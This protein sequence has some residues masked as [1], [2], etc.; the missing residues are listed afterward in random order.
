MKTFNLLSMIGLVLMFFSVNKELYAGAYIFAGDANGVD[1]VAHSKNY[2]GTGG[3]ITNKVCIVVGSNSAASLE[4]PVQN[5][6]D[7]FNQLVA[8]EGNLLTGANNDIAFNQVDIESALLHEIGHC[9]GMAHPNAA[10]ESGLPSAD[11][12]YTKATEGTNAVFD[13]NSGV[14]GVRG[15]SDD[16]RGDDENLHWFL[17]DS[18]NPF[19]TPDGAVDQSNYSRDLADLPLG[20]SFATNA[21]RTVSGLYGLPSTEATMQQ[22]QGFDEDQR[23]IVGDDV[24]TL[25]FARSGNDHIS[26]TADDYTLNLIYGGISNASD[27]DITVALDKSTGFAVCRTGGTFLPGNNIAITSADVRYNETFNWFFT[28]KR[29]P[30]PVTDQLTVEIGGTVTLV[31]GGSSSLLNNDTHPDLLSLNMSTQVFRG[32]FHGNVTLNANGTFSYSHTGVTS[33]PDLFV[34]KTCVD[35]AG[36]TNTCSYG[37]VNVLVNENTEPNVAPILTAIGDQSVGEL[38]T[39]TF[40][41]TATDANLPADNLTFSLSGEPIGASITE[42]GMFNF[43]PAEAQGPGDYSFDVIVTDDGEG[44]LSDFE[45]IIV[46]VNEENTAPILNNIGNQSINALNT[47]NFTAIATDTDLPANTLSYRLS[48]EPMGAT[49]T[50]DGNFSFTPTEAQSPNDYTFD[51]IVADNGTGLLEDMETITVTVNEANIAPELA[52]IGMQSIDE[53]EM[54]SFTATATDADMPSQTLTFSLSGE[55]DGAFISSS[56]FFS[57]TPTELQGPEDYIFEVIVTDNGP[58]ELSD[59][60]MITVTVNEVNIAP[61]LDD[62]GNQSINELALLTFSASATDSDLPANDLTFSLAGEP[63]G[64]SITTDGEFS[65]TPTET[66]GSNDYT[67]D[68]IVSDNGTGELMDNETITITVNETNTA[69][70]LTSIGNQSINELAPLNFTASATDSD[71]PANGLTFSLAGE[72]S[73]ASITTDGEFSFTPIEAQGPNDYTFDVIVSDNGTGTLM[74]NE[75]IT[76][77]V[78]EVNTAPELTFIG[79]QTINELETLSFTATATDVD[80]P[81]NTLTFSLSGEPEGASISPTG[82][83]LF[84][85][86]KTQSLDE[87]TFDVIVTDNGQGLLNDSETITVSVTD[88]IFLNGFEEDGE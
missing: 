26:G 61:E 74:D 8:I 42:G 16:I 29:I 47:L 50:S 53:M 72:P 36:A 14:D 34:Y 59:S 64:A 58:G 48:G 20:S 9:I 56:G 4:I 62:I 68:V 2:N 13:I 85:P 1:L 66:Q 30:A 44:A 3:I 83:F 19:V 71:L 43:T 88:I 33:D 41:A 6:I 11:R 75:T 15:S 57:F 76:I 7:R 67:F 18:N 82:E 78:N 39:L 10:V 84:T 65:F 35:D 24:N 86:S 40:T 81:V 27:C 31:D 52:S 51:V 22:G 63:L 45:T 87:F 5:S 55:P 23:A 38:E 32:P 69:P 21:D 54:L 77:T 73:G 12:E 60:E 17:T 37:V 46:T 28:S 80:L 70:E 79:D 25:L 49:I